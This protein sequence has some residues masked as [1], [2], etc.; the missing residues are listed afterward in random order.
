MLKPLLRALSSVFPTR[1]EQGRIVSC[2]KPQPTFQF[3]P[4]ALQRG[5]RGF[6]TETIHFPSSLAL[7]CGVGVGEI[8]RHLAASLQSSAAAASVASAGLSLPWS[9]LVWTQ[10][11]YGSSSHLQVSMKPCSAKCMVFPMGTL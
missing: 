6:P 9:Q 8:L 2:E 7:A 10:G 5:R 4:G 3:L 11:G 1:V